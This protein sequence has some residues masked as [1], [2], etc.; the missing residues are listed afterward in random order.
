MH[1]DRPHH[2]RPAGGRLGP[3][4]RPA[5]AA[6]ACAGALVAGSACAYLAVPAPAPPGESGATGGDRRQ[7]APGRSAVPAPPVRIVRRRIPYG[8]ARRA[9]MAAYS[10]RHYGDRSWWLRPR[11]IV[12]HYT[13]GPT[14]ESA[15]AL[16]ASNAPNGGE[17][18]G[19]CAHYIV[20]KDGTVYA[21]VP[22]T[23]RCRHAIGL[24][25]NAI[26]V[27]MVQEAGPSSSWADR[28]I[29]ARPTQI[30]AAVG[31]VARLQRRFGIPARRVIGH[32]MANASPDFHD[33]LGW[34]ND[35]TDWLA[36]DVAAFRRLLRRASG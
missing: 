26:G 10:A 18:P 21:L 5:L 19:T 17:L 34:R 31:L 35:H 22:P 6:V 32:A 36:A 3:F 25:D 4:G 24:N 28:Q 14:M 12:L 20:D 8:P 23:V 2:E 30:R 27:E 11:T 29:L 16:F 15:W 1:G 9:Q 13:A 7:A 33:R